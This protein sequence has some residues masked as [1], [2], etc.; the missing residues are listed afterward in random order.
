MK[1]KRNESTRKASREI[2]RGTDS[3]KSLK[4]VKFFH[5]K[6][7]NLKSKIKTTS[8]SLKYAMIWV[9]EKN[10]IWF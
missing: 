1:M 9:D 5:S 2:R 4:I 6:N 7:S 10:I 8:E 3:M